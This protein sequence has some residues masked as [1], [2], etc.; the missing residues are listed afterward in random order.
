MVL[1]TGSSVS[2]INRAAIKTM[3]NVN[4]FPCSHPILKL[5]NGSSMCPTGYILID[6]EYETKVYPIKFYIYDGLPF[7]YLLGLDFCQLTK[8]NINFDKI[9][10]QNDENSQTLKTLPFYYHENDN[11]IKQYTNLYVSNYTA[12][13]PMS[14]H[15]VNVKSKVAIPKEFLFYADNYF[16]HKTPLIIRNCIQKAM[17]K[18]HSLIFAVNTTSHWVHLRV[19]TKLGHF[20]NY[21]ND[22]FCFKFEFNDVAIESR[23]INLPIGPEGNVATKCEDNPPIEVV[24][25]VATKFENLNFPENQAESINFNIGVSLESNEKEQLISFLNKNA[26][27]FARNISELTQT[28]LITHK[29]RTTPHEP[30]ARGPY[31]ASPKERKVIE[32]EVNKLL[33][34][35]L[36]EPSDSPYAAPV[37]IVWKKNGKPRF[38]CDYRGINSIT[39]MDSYPLPR[40]DDVLYSFNAAK[41]FSSLDMAS[42]YWQVPVEPNDIE[43]TAFITPGGLFQWKVAPFGLKTVPETYQRLIDKVIQGLKCNICIGYLDDLIIWS[44]DFN[45]QLERLQKVFDAIRNANLRMNPEKCQFCRDRNYL[46]W[47]ITST[48][49]EPDPNKVKSVTEFPRPK[50]KTEVRRFIGMCSYYR[51]TVSDFASIA[52]PLHKL[53]SKNTEFK[54]TEVEESAFIELKHR[55]CTAP[56]LV[57]FDQDKP[58]RVKADASDLGIGYVLVHLIEGVE[59]PF[60]YG[61]RS[62]HIHENNYAATKLESLAVHFAIT[63]NRH[64]LLG[65]K[66]QVI[67]DHCNLCYLLKAQDLKSSQSHW[68]LDLLEYEFTI[69]Y[70]SGKTHGDADALSRAP[71]PSNPDDCRDKTSVATFFNNNEINL[72]TMQ[73]KDE[74]CKKVYDLVKTSIK[75][76]VRLGGKIYEL[77]NDIVIEICGQRYYQLCVPSELRKEVLYSLHDDRTAG[78]LGIAKVYD[79]LRRRFYWPKCFQSVENYVNRCED[80][81]TKKPPVGAKFGLGQIPDTPSVPFTY[82]ALDILGPFPES[83]RG[84]KYVMVVSDLCTRYVTTVAVGDIKTTT[85]AN[86][87]IENVF[88]KYGFPDKLLTD[89]AKQFLSNIWQALLEIL[90]T[91]HKRTTSY[92]CQTNGIVEN[93]N[94]VLTT[95]LSMYCNSNQ[96]NWCEALQYITF[97]YNTSRHDSSKFSPYYLVF[98]REPRL[99]CDAVLNLPINIETVDQVLARLID[100]RTLARDFIMDAQLRN[101]VFYDARRRESP[102]RVGDRVYCF[103][104]YRKVGRSDKLLHRYFGPLMVTQVLSP[105]TVRVESE[106]GRRSEIVNVSRLKKIMTIGDEANEPRGPEQEALQNSDNDIPVVSQQPGALLAKKTKRKYTKRLIPYIIR[107]SSRLKRAP[108]RLSY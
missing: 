55:L 65:V 67:T 103:T 3:P 54:W 8:L 99:I 58:I 38:C 20:E 51:T 53:T 50:S 47:V 30:I 80:C 37:V 49:L 10:K 48:G 101:K 73:Q 6:I 89:N 107:K 34:H 41:L 63:S 66:F 81:L 18:S 90:G 78:H 22:E 76:P 46:G 36:I 77:L 79:K 35:G 91:K 27:L 12:I 82:I 93:A 15:W 95:S 59:H 42:G 72:H 84:N 31:R 94:K 40:L 39:I 52:E 85:L 86:A 71:Q 106:D 97:G 100:A 108:K 13:P 9:S 68:V 45:Q 74:W 19:G 11:E 62:L 5:A 87:L 104:P 83:I 7:E 69:V 57:H 44:K 29:I 105:V 64:Y 32:Q 14:G 1:D 17:S 43:K 26:D 70:K 56:T 92:H 60:K 2:V 98:G 88:L 21:N 24:D 16:K 28:H 102:F 96:L 23:D 25:S 4:I 33:Q 75:Q 61:S